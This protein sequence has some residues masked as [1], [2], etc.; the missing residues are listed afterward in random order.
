MQFLL[1]AFDGTDSQAS[2]RRARARDRH[3]AQC[4]AMVADGRLLFGTA[5]LDEAGQMV[6]SMLVT[7]FPTRGD[8]DEWLRGEPY[9]TDDVWADIRIHPCR[10]GRQFIGQ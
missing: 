6:G 7:E 9:V 2:E 4:D 5:I 1:M 10:A 8:L 3:L